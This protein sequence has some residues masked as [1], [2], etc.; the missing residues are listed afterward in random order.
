[1]VELDELNI[2]MKD[3]LKSTFLS[4][5][6]TGN[7]LFDT[8]IS[9]IL[10]TFITTIMSKMLLNMSLK[11]VNLCS[12]S[13]YIIKLKYIFKRQN[14]IKIVGRKMTDSYMKTR[15]DFSMRFQA[16]IALLNDMTR[17]N[18]L[19][20]NIRKLS[21]FQ[22]REQI[23]Y[24]R[25]TDIDEVEKGFSFIVDQKQIIYLTDDIFC[26][27]KCDTEVDEVG[28]SV[29]KKLFTR[30]TYSIY[31]FSYK[32]SCKELFDYL[33]NITDTYEQKQKHFKNVNKYILSYEGT[34][35]NEE[36]MNSVMWRKEQF[37]SNK[38]FSN[39]FFDGKEEVLKQIYDFV[40]GRDLYKKI[41][42]PYHLGILL[43]GEP[44]CGKTSFINAL[45]NELGRNIKEINFSKLNT[46]DDLD[47]SITC[48]EYESIDMD[49]D[50]VIIS[51]EDIDCATDIVKCR[52][53]KE[54]EKDSESTDEADDGDVKNMVKALKMLSSDESFKK[55]PKNKN[56]GDDDRCVKNKGSKNITL[57]NLLNVIDGSREMPGRIIII[58]T[59]VIDWLDEALVREGRMDIKVEMKRINSDLI[60][61][62]LKNYRNAL[63]MPFTMEE[64]DEWEKN[65]QYIVPHPPCKAI[66]KIQRYGKSLSSLIESLKECN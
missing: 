43:Y 49:Y 8:I 19:N 64:C 61:D 21:E 1:M 7:V 16:F 24:N 53:L 42:K 55:K 60:K 63:N 6:K 36:S 46:A 9:F 34:D 30:E 26:K 54:S 57:S 37:R 51:F 44:G 3:T 38:Q 2:I 22:V 41:G 31:I 25:D 45:A 17:E 5:A 32:Y 56:S 28:H 11:N 58:T 13:E 65:K 35:S 33:D 29:N 14:T 62:M 4:Y 66:N 15:I 50:K 23:K 52:K 18:P 20:K 48:T 39:M 40:N 27:I 47:K 12:L 59:N 10:M